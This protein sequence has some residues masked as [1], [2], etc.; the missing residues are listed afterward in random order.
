MKRTDTITNS[1]NIIDS[2]DI[3][4]RIEYLRGELDAL[5]DAVTDAETD[6]DR[7]TAQEAFAEWLGGNA[8]DGVPTSEDLAAP[9]S[10]QWAKS[11]DAEE[12]SAL[13]NLADECEG[14]GDWS[15]GDTLIRDSHF[16]EYAQQLAEDIDAIPDDAKWPCIC[17][18]WEKAADVLRADYCEVNFDGE[19]YLIRA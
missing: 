15:H 10:K 7:K 18:D 2:R 12:L 19:T 5:L 17:I 13:E 11:D 6:E 1:E 14:Y 16:T 8:E 9:L 3:I 4:A